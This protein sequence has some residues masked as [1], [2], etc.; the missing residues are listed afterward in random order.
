[1]ISD[2]KHPYS[3]KTTYGYIALDTMSL[4]KLGLVYTVHFG[5]LDVFLFERRRGHLIFWRESLAVSTP[6]QVSP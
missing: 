4:A 5:N 1:M 3:S 6:G 2:I